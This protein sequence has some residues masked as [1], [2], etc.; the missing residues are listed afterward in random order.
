MS[1]DL[2]KKDP[3][4]YKAI[5]NI[6]LPELEKH[7]D[8]FNYLV[9]C[10]TFQQL[11]GKAGATIHG[12]VL[13]IYGKR[14]PLPGEVL[15]TGHEVL[16]AAG[17]SNQ[18]A[19]YIRN[20]AQ[21]WLDEKLSNRQLDGMSDEDILRLLT[22]IK[23]VGQ[24]TVEVL[25]I[26]GMQR[27]DLFPLDDLGIQQGMALLY[28]WENQGLKEL[29]KKMQEKAEDWRPNRSLASRFIWAWKDLPE[30]KIRKPVF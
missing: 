1:A 12:R 26:F 18:K 22:R 8:Y 19:T 17:L 28:G 9:R 16:R 25:L 2:F 4:L 29:K 23:G 10:I 3:V 27:S 24:W 15:Q 6:S 30:N 21:F 20:I 14:S 11:S 5:K 7:D 13:D